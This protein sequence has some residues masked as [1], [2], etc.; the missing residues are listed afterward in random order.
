MP[1]DARLLREAQEAY[2]LW[3]EAELRERLH[4]IDKQS[5]QESWQQ[6]VTLVE[7]CWKLA[8]WPS[9]HQRKQKM[10][11]LTQYY[12]RVQKLEMWRGQHGKNA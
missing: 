5:P 4:A 12:D 11:A 2:R 6:Y 9:E 3:N 7:F 8:P 10:A 1:I